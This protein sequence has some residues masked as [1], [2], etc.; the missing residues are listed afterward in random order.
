MPANERGHTFGAHF[1]QNPTLAD[2]RDL[3]VPSSTSPPRPPY[4]EGS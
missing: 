3:H 2:P 1:M 4:Y